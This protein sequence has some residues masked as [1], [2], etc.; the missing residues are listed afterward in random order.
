MAKKEGDTVRQLTGTYP[1]DYGCVRA[2]LATTVEQMVVE[3]C[4]RIINW[5]G[6]WG[7]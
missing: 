2:L 3:S 5:K 6:K 4:E 1:Y 7:D